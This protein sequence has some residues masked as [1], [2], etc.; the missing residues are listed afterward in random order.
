LG[1]ERLSDRFHAE[2]IFR[3][4]I[5]FAKAALTADE[6]KFPIRFDVNSYGEGSIAGS[7]VE[8]ICIGTNHRLDRVTFHLPNFPNVTTDELFHD[9]IVEHG[10][11]THISW[12]QVLL[13]YGGWLITLQPYGHVHMLIKSALFGQYP[14]LSGVGEIRKI[15]SGN[16]KPKHVLPVLESLRVFLSFAFAAWKTPAFVVGSNSVATRS[17][18]RFSAYESSVH[19]FS[20]GWL[21]ERHGQHLTQAYP[22][23]CRL[24][25]KERWRLPVNQAVTWLI[26]ASTTSGSIQGAIAFSQIPLEMLAW[27]VFV[28]ENAI[29]D[30]NEFENLSAGNKLQLLLH[31]C[32]IP[33]GVPPMLETL[34]KI[35]INDEGK[36][37]SGP[38]IATEIRNTI[39]HPHKKNRDKFNGWITQHKVEGNDL[40]RE[41][42]HLFIWYITLV[43]LR[44]ME[45]D[46]EYAN[47]LMPQ[48]PN[49]IEKVPWAAGK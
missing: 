26:E 5:T 8:P 15:E 45:Y 7:I 11:E 49:T 20:Q 46:G 9:I 28:D 27:L 21:D 33:L 37:K 41:T 1:R 13:E 43:L 3:E 10:K 4:D 23:F 48:R 18:Q 31:E 44:L 14:V 6:T 39:I 32:G 16:F 40:L 29:L 24:W 17:V 22:G 2:S 25:D 42:Q 12:S 38:R 19:W 34:A 35:A 30:S 36:Q 47:R